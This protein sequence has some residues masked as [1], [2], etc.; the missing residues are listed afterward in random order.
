MRGANFEALP[1]WEKGRAIPRALRRPPRQKE[2]G[3]PDETVFA[4]LAAGLPIVG[5]RFG[6]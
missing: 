6:A 2:R 1:L 5:N 3:R 4:V